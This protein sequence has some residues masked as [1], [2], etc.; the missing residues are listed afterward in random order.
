VISCILDD[1]EITGHGDTKVLWASRRSERWAKQR[2]A[3]E[4]QTK[5]K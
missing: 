2:K 5:E 1:F 3:D 4:R